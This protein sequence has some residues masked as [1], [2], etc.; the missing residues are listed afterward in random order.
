M[1][2]NHDSGKE[3]TS[4]SPREVAKK[5]PSIEVIKRESTE[6]I[7]SDVIV[8]Y[9]SDESLKES[10]VCY[11]FSPKK[12]KRARRSVACRALIAQLK[13]NTTNNVSPLLQDDSM[14]KSI[15]AIAVQPQ[16]EEEPQCIYCERSPCILEQG[17]YDLLVEGGLL[18]ED[19]DVQALK[20]QIRFDMYRKAAR[21]MWGPLKKGDRRK[22]PHCVL[23]EIHDFAPEDDVKK[24][25]G[26]KVIGE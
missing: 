8:T 13:E 6:S 25:T 9:D 3:A 7:P 15:A 22:L 19:D 5:A 1:D 17:L 21:F 24:Y 20:K 26:F 14:K 12:R 2:D 16:P 11:H 23:Q 18:L 4:S 10:S